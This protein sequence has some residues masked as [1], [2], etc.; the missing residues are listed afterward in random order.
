MSG[1]W[2]SHLSGETRAIRGNHPLLLADPES[3]WIVRSGSVALFAVTVE[4][5][6]PAGARRHL[7]TVAPGDALLGSP[8]GQEKCRA[9]LAVSLEETELVR[10]RADELAQVAGGAGGGAERLL[11]GWVRK[12]NSALA[13]GG[14]LRLPD[15]EGT[16]DIPDAVS[17][18]HIEFLRQID[19]LERSD[20]ERLALRLQERGRFSERATRETLGELA[21]VVRPALRAAMY[22]RDTAFV[23][24]AQAV[25][26]AAGI[27]FPPPKHRDG[28]AQ[29]GDA[30]KAIERSARIRSRR[31]LLTGTWWK[32]DCGPLLAYTLQD[33]KPVA[34]LPRGPR[35]YILFDPTAGRRIRVD[36]SVASSLQ[37]FAYVFYRPLPDKV[38][39]PQD[40]LL[41]GLKGTQRDVALILMAA[42]AGTLLGMFTPVAM[43][44]LIDSA[45]PDSDRAL[46]LQLGA[47]LLGAAFGKTFFDLA[48]A[49]ATTRA[50]T[51]SITVMQAAIWDRLLKLRPSFLRQYSTG[52]L[53]SRAMAIATIH[54]RLSTTTLRT[55]FSSSVSLLN[56][57][58]MFYYSLQLALIGIAAALVTVLITLASGKAMLQRLRPLQQMEGKILGLTV[59]L[60]N[61]ISKLRVSGTERFAFA[62]WGKRY[63]EQQRLVLS[64]QR[65]QDWIGSLNQTVPTLAVGWIFLVAGGT[66]L[67]ATTTEGGL[68]AGAFLAFN[69][70]FGAFIGGMASLSNTVVDTLDDFNL[71]QR[72]KPILSAEPESDPGKTDPGVLR[73]R[74]AVEHVTFRYRDSGPLTLEDVSF[75]AEPG[76]FVAFVGPSGGGKSTVFRLL[77]GFELPQ[78]GTVY[79]DGQDLNGL[80]V[81]AVRRQLGVV[82]QNS[83][84]LSGSIFE[85]I[86]A[87]A[88]VTLDQ[89]WE[90]ARQAGIADDISTFPMGMHTFISEGA[91]NIS[92]GQRQRLLIARALVFRPRILLFD[93]ATSAL[94]NRAQAIVSE[95]LERLRV[96][97]LVVAHRLS[98][99]RGAD[100]IYVIE[101]GR[102][103]QQGNFAGLASQDG[104]FARMMSRQML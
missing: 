57:G 81:F 34:L 36:R 68:S 26:R 67:G 72:A 60:I 46:L 66:F 93:E 32:S 15:M 25:G 48:Q 44:V 79:F 99:I 56:L 4:K 35:R 22:Q 43:S 20:E 17:Q 82:L 102:L 87:G 104:L 5:G 65:L 30:L 73:G 12:L 45:I 50:S 40:I 42:L 92:V 103:V 31:V 91:T 100:R 71:W 59:Q 58:L 29:P 2:L 14:D 88:V 33:G 27:E 51:A 39:R 53:S 16:T 9:L 94:D 86:A 11:S 101:H 6:Q 62:Y 13:D 1:H 24:A 64:V 97:R 96:T 84:L 76:E 80:D 41:F 8:V 85:N 7:F 70:A 55:L 37:P 63:S 28:I 77:L 21:S 18:L 98:T 61:G 54:R 95:S 49:F 83:N 89:A 75:H 19:R 52:D 3:I 78:S 74:I 90:A 23:A 38:A 10:I 69:A 47:G